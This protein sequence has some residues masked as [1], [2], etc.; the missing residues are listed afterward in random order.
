MVRKFDARSASRCLIW[1]K[2]L[3]G[4]SFAGG[5]KMPL[6]STDQRLLLLLQR[7][8]DLPALELKQT[9]TAAATSV[10]QW[11]ECEKTDAFLFDPA[12]TCLVAVGTSET[13]LGKLQR[14]LGLDVL[15]LANG[16]RLAETYRTGESYVTGRADEDS[17]ELVG[18][19]RDLGVRSAINVP[20]D[21]GGVRRGVLS[22]VSQK[23][24]SFDQDDVVVLQLIARWVSAV[25][26]RAE[27]VERLRA[28]ERA[29]ARTTAVE[30]IVTVLAHDLRNHL[31]PLA[32]RLQLMQIRLRGGQPLDPS[33]LDSAL[34]AVTRMSRLTS[35]LL[36]VSRL[37]QGLFELELRPVDLGVLVR[38][39]VAAINTPTHEVQASGEP[40]LTAVADAERLRQALENVLANAVRHS[41]Q[42]RP[43]RVELFTLESSKQ[44]RICVTDE[45]P[46]IAPE[47]LPHLFDR[48]VS[49]QRSKGIGLGLYLA[50]RITRAHGGSLEVQSTLGAGA[51]FCFTLPLEGP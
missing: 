16:G 50:E 49:S 30:E 14:A 29:R 38:E 42:G 25:S 1:S 5:E 26:Q 23:P 48:F 41:P 28:E 17:G 47:L 39:T 19:V 33:L 51:R 12:R 11:C 15:P 24:D 4:T 31:A 18:I 9:L 45:G 34:A 32:G 37:D 13:P 3:D 44:A 8:L 35:S 21:I 6:A 36:D 40:T 46:G 43:V 20:L 10:A 7:L 2:R 27:L 22:V